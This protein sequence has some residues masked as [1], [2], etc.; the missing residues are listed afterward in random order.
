MEDTRVAYR[1]LEGTRE[2]R[3]PLGRHMH[4]WRIILKW[5]FE[6]W[7]GRASTGSI[8]LRIGINGGLL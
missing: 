6:K 4:R 8:W 2:R 1:V 7:V 3:R 5:M